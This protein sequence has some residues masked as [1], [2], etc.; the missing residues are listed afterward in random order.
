MRAQLDEV[1]TDA[2]ERS[3]KIFGDETKKG[4][5]TRM[6]MMVV[7]MITCFINGAVQTN[8]RR[9]KWARLAGARCLQF[10]T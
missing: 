7:M 3:E 6:M 8:T 10:A 1:V 9:R 2:D 5:T 4:V